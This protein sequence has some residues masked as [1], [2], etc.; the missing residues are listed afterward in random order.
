MD[1]AKRANLSL[2]LLISGNS[3]EDEFISL[4][5]PA[6]AA[7]NVEEPPANSSRRPERTRPRKDIGTL[8]GELFDRVPI[9]DEHHLRRELTEYLGHYNGARADRSLGQ[10]IP[11]QPIPAARTDQ[12]RGVP[13]PPEEVLGRLTTSTTSLLTAHGSTPRTVFRALQG[14]DPVTKWRRSV[15]R[16]PSGAPSRRKRRPGRRHAARRVEAH[17]VRGHDDAGRRYGGRGDVELA[18]CVVWRS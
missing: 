18:A 7:E 6:S 2:K 4:S 17:P 1:L 11:A 12:H 3:R 10:P 8:R 15:R 14:L 9:V 5:M 16:N 13:D